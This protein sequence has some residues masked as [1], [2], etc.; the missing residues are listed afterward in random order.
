MMSW[1]VLCVDLLLLVISLKIYAKKPMNPMILFL[2]LWGFIIFLSCLNLYGMDKASNETWILML[3]MIL[4]FFLG[5][6]VQKSGRVLV[7]Q[8]RIFKNKHEMRK[9]LF[10]FLTILIFGALFYNCF[11]VMKYIMK[12]VT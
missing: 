5:S 12:E 8:N 11:E 6:V 10:V 2:A 7:N 3:S 4:F 9:K 1:L